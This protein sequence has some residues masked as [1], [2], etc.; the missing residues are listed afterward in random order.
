M[1]EH[2]SFTE[3]A[4]KHTWEARGKDANGVMQYKCSTCP[5]WGYQGYFGIREK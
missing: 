4:H 2:F 5:K 1:T 3:A